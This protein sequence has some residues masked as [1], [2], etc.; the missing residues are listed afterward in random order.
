[1]SERYKVV[2]TLNDIPCS[3]Q[4]PVG[5]ICGKPAYSI[6]LMPH[7]QA[8]SVY[9]MGCWWAMPICDDCA[10]ARVVSRGTNVLRLPARF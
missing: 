10:G 6:V 8:G 4:L 9:V 5:G 3:V 1:M 7:I 2:R